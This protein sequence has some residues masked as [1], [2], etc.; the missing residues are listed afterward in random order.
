MVKHFIRRFVHA[1]DT[2]PVMMSVA[3]VGTTTMVGVVLL[4]TV[5]KIDPISD[6]SHYRQLTIQEANFQAM[7]EIARQSTFREKLQNAS[8]ATENL[9]MQRR[10][11]HYQ[12]HQEGGGGEASTFMNR[13]HGRGKEILRQNQEYLRQRTELEHEKEQ[14]STTKIW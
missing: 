4:N 5:V 3:T 9:M 8:F 14:W 6:H 10:V 11:E 12:H 2:Y 1:V 7:L 13:I